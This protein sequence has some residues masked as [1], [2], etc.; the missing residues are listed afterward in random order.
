MLYRLLRVAVAFMAP[1]SLGGCMP[2]WGH[3][4]TPVLPLGSG[5][6]VHDPCANQD[7]RFIYDRSGV[8]LR[9]NFH[10]ITTDSNLAVFM[11]D[12]TTPKEQE[13]EIDGSAS[14]LRSKDAEEYRATELATWLYGTAGSKNVPLS[15]TYRSKGSRPRRGFGLDFEIDPT[16]DWTEAV[17]VLPHI[18]VDGKTI[19]YPDTRFE[20]RKFFAIMAWNC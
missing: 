15:Y 17:V 14:V 1:I 4:Y 5:S 10:E 19:E 8:I 13:V 11:F 12:I 18:S 3:Y 9:G 20:R 6:I 7:W 2:I 16:D